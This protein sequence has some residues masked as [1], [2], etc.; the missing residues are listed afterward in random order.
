MARTKNRRV[1]RQRGGVDECD[2]Q[3]LS[4]A[5]GCELNK[6]TKKY[7]INAR[8]CINKLSDF[9]KTNGE[10]YN[11]CKD[12]EDDK[13][14]NIEQESHRMREQIGVL[15]HHLLPLSNE[16][17]HIMDAPQIGGKRRRKTSKRKTSRRKHYKK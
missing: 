16:H 1:K 9:C 12:Y 11:A 15:K 4:A 14:Y 8:N 6:D 2:Y 13:G 5:A 17:R 10:D 3:I 7:N